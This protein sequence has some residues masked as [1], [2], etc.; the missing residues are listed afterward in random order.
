MHLWSIVP[1]IDPFYIYH[2]HITA[3]CFVVVSVCCGHHISHPR[4]T[5]L[6][7]FLIF[8]S[9]IVHGFVAGLAVGRV[10][11]PLPVLVGC[12]LRDIGAALGHVEGR[13]D[14]APSR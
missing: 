11:V 4:K 13:V 10:M 12:W 3:T 5:E 1:C 7:A 2:C 8:S 9:T 6:C 14:D